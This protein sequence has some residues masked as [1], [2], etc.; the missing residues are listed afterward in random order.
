MKLKTYDVKPRSDSINSAFGDSNGIIYDTTHERI[1][2]KVS[3]KINRTNVIH[4]IGSNVRSSV[5]N[6]IVIPVIYYLNM[7]GEHV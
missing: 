3:I 7:F 4:H 2:R 5:G 1:H 6:C